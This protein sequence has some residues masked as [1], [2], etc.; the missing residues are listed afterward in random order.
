MI[1]AKTIFAAVVM[2]GGLFAAPAMAQDGH[3]G[4]EHAEQVDWSFA[5]LFGTYDEHQLQ[6]GFKVF[7]EVCSSCHAARL[8]SYRNL[9]QEGG[10]NY[11]EDQVKLLASQITIQDPDSPGGERPGRPSDS[12]PDPFPT[13]ADARAANNGI[14]P[15]DFSVLAKARGIGMDF[16]WWV[17][18]YF[19][20]YQEGGPDFIY[21][22]LTSYTEPPEGEEL[23]PGQHYNAFLGAGTSMPSPLSDG[24]IT[25]E[26]EEGEQVPETVDQYAKDVSAFMMWLAEPHLTSRKEM[27]FR[28][29]IFL[30]V[31]AVLMYMVK[32][33]LWRNVEH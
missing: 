22:V 9:E 19:T 2:A 13:P 1:N 24:L 5:G 26:G 32:R 14:V 31:F 7:Q 12:W 17:F 28:A 10:P 33:R 8:L 6:R 29:L 30:G 21:N 20:A 11:S 25:Y 18:N 3:G 4:G 27:G 16:P 15:P 23:P